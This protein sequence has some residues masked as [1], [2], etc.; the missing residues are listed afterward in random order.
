MKP[1]ERL[2]INARH[3]IMAKGGVA[4]ARRIG[5][6]ELE[7]EVAPDRERL[8]GLTGGDRFAKRDSGCGIARRVQDSPR[9]GFPDGSG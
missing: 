1:G 3:E 5:G 4:A 8:E 9:P 7:F 2:A 6:Q